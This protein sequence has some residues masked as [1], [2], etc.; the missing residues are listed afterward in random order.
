MVELDNEDV[1]GRWFVRCNGCGAKSGYYRR[2]T[3]ATEAWNTRHIAASK[4]VVTPEEMDTAY[5]EAF[6]ECADAANEHQ[7]T[8]RRWTGV[9]PHQAG[10]MAIFT[11][12]QS[13]TPSVGEVDFKKVEWTVRNWWAKQMD[14]EGV[15]PSDEPQVMALLSDLQA[16]IKGGGS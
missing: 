15:Q 8:G 16:L 4:P 2:D 3:G 9:N 12:L 11:L 1:S 6:V 5:N 14:A 7:A 13:R 10:I